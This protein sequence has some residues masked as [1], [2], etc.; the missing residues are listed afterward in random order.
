[1]R[2]KADIVAQAAQDVAGN[3]IELDL[4]GTPKQRAP[5]K[6]SSV[7][8]EAIEVNFKPILSTFPQENAL[9]YSR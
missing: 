8:I 1:M 5:P 7:A 2:N 4:P 6:C 9:P 3:G